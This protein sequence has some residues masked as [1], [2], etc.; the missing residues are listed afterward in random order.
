[1]KFA[2]MQNPLTQI[3]FLLQSRIRLSFPTFYN[4]RK[5]SRLKMVLES[6]LTSVQG[7][8]DIFVISIVAA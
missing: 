7:I 4:G 3:H 5:S 2:F 8:P 6:I 1:M